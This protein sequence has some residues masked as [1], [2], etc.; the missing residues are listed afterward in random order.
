MQTITYSVIA[1]LK[2]EKRVKGN[3]ASILLRIT[4][5]SQRAEIYIKRKVDTERWDSAANRVKGK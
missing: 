1:Y 3:L 5:N 2:K 4:V